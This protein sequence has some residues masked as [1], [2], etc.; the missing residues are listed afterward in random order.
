M[1]RYTTRYV[2][3]VSLVITIIIYIFLS[4]FITNLKI[5]DFREDRFALTIKQNKNNFPHSCVSEMKWNAAER[6]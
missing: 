5:F 6:N 1:I 3:I 2:N 4:Y